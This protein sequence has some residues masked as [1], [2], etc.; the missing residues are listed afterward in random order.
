GSTELPLDPGSVVVVSGGARGVTASSVAA[1]A[2]AWGVRLAL[3]GRSGLEEWPEGVPLTTDAVQ[4]T[5][6]LAKAA[7]DRGESVDLAALQSHARA[8]AAS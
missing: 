2:E 1:M 4:I 8:L 5:G 3:L 7:K 6:A